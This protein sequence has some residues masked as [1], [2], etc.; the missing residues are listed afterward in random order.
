[1]IFLDLDIDQF[2][3]HSMFNSERGS[4]VSFVF[5]L[6]RLSFSIVSIIEMFRLEITHFN[7]H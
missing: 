6:L 1:M 3:E 7:T 5:S 2:P 4:Y